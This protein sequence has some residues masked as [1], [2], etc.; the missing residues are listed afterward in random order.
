VS[1]RTGLPGFEVELL[2]A[3]N[4][5]THGSGTVLTSELLAAVERDGVVGPRAAQV[6]LVDLL[7]PWRRH[8]TLVR[9]VGNWGSQHGDPPADP[10]Y[11]EVGLTPYGQL[12][13]AAED[14]LASGRRPGRDGPRLGAVDPVT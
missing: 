14:G 8:L 9:G 5:A 10:E 6:M 2:R 11:T 4:R 3:I 1:E 7:A 13:L 12:A